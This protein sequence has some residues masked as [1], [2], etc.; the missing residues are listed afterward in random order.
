[1]ERYETFVTGMILLIIGVLLVLNWKFLTESTISYHISLWERLGV[2]QSSGRNQKLMTFL[3]AVIF[4]IVIGYGFVVLGL[5]VLYGFV[6][7]RDWPLHYASW[8]D[9]WPF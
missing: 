4:K 9:L 1:M 5:L 3:G 6:T 7:G 8:K 2:Q